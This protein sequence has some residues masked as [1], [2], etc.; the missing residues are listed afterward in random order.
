M[1]SDKI[2][3]AK[4]QADQVSNSSSVPEQADKGKFKYP[5]IQFKKFDSSIRDWL[6]FWAQF[7][8]VGEDLS[9]DLADVDVVEYLVQTTARNLVD[10]FPATAENY[11][12][13]IEI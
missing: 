12:L 11:K 3:Q 5:A 4:Q 7:K 13:I 8:K 6:S 9:I 2:W 1:K 10:S